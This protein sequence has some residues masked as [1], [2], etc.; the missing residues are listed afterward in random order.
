MILLRT[1]N[2]IEHKFWMVNHWLLLY[3]ILYFCLDQ[4]TTKREISNWT[5][6]ENILK[7]FSNWNQTWYECSVDGPLR[8]ICFLCLSKVLH[9][10]IT[11]QSFHIGL[12]GTMKQTNSHKLN[13]LFK[14]R[15][16]RSQQPHCLIYQ[17][18]SNLLEPKGD[19]ITLLVIQT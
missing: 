12:Y 14:Q 9:D 16:T 5:L 19:L 1:G 8:S 2:L 4:K 18:F 17:F 7:L 6:L 13:T 15:N 3:K 11:Q 10:A